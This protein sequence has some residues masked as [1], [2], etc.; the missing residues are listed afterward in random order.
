MT[1]LAETENVLPPSVI[2]VPGRVVVTVDPSAS[3]EE[4]IV[5]VLVVKAA[6]LPDIANEVSWPDPAALDVAGVVAALLL[7]GWDSPVVR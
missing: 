3:T 4:L 7:S 6:V 5:S 2:V 1:A